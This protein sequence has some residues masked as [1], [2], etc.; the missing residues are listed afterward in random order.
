MVSCLD[1]AFW[2]AI[3][4]GSRWLGGKGVLAASWARS[5]LDVSDRDLG[6]APFDGDSGIPE[7]GEDLSQRGAELA[8]V[9]LSRVGTRISYSLD[10]G[11]VGRKYGDVRDLVLVKEE[12]GLVGSQGEGAEVG[13]E[14]GGGEPQLSS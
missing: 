13:V 10:G 8:G 3:V 5:M 1:E 12:L 6:R 7:H 11:R 2:K 9:R 4:F 14:V